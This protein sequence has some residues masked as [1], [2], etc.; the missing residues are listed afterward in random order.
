M[1]KHVIEGVTYDTENATK[2]AQARFENYNEM[3]VET[4]YATGD[5]RFFLDVDN[6]LDHGH[7]F[8]TLTQEEAQKWLHRDVVE[9]IQNSIGE[10]K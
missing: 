5:G 3:G 10:T 2:V 4:L 8:K 9:I 6:E 7:E 1:I